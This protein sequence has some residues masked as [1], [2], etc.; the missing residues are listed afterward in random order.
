MPPAIPELHFLGHLFNCPRHW[1]ILKV[2]NSVTFD[3][4]T[5]LIYDGPESK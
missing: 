2:G 4:Y 3:P 1:K 5:Y